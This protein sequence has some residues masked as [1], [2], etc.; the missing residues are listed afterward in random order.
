MSTRN[1]EIFLKMHTDTERNLSH[2]QSS[3]YQLS[4]TV[5][6]YGAATERETMP[7]AYG[8]E[9]WEDAPQSRTFDRKQRSQS[10]IRWHILNF[11][12]YRLRNPP[13]FLM[14]AF[15][16]NFILLTYLLCKD[17]ITVESNTQL[18]NQIRYRQIWLILHIQSLYRVAPK[19]GP[20]T[21]ICQKEP[22]NLLRVPSSNVDQFSKFFHLSAILFVS[23]H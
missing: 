10:H 4:S 19:S 17:V 2:L 20:S 22:R 7:K 11:T 23:H 6:V 3:D 1:A 16:Q 14:L 9:H 15:Q 12:N 13:P 18:S 8:N 21:T 5:Y